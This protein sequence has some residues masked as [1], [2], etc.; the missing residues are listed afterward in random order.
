V[1]QALDALDRAGAAL[2]IVSEAMK[3]N[4]EDLEKLAYFF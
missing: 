2:K 4:R 1:K 3:K